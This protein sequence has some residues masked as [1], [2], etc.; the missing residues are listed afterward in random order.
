MDQE[1]RADASI[2]MLVFH[3]DCY[4]RSVALFVASILRDTGDDFPSLAFKNGKNDHLLG[5][6]DSQEY[7]L[8]LL[9]GHGLSFCHESFVE[10]GFRKRIEEISQNSFVA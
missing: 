5:I 9:M 3:H 8:K 7:P 6:V 4:F 10:G 2:L 1:F